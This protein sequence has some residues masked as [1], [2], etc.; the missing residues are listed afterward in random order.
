MNFYRIQTFIQ[1]RRLDTFTRLQELHQ[2]QHNMLGDT[3]VC[4]TED[5]RLLY[6]PSNDLITKI[7]LAKFLKDERLYLAEITSFPVGESISFDHTFKVA[8]NI[9]FH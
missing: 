6:S 5:K 4:E 1:E 8:A 2:V 9:G 7:V 3:K